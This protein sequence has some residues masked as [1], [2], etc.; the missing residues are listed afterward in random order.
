M[1]IILCTYMPGRHA[2]NFM[3]TR[4]EC[5]VQHVCACGVCVFRHVCV[6]VQTLVCMCVYVYVRAFVRSLC[7][8]ACTS[9][10][11]ACARTHHIHHHRRAEA[12]SLALQRHTAR[13]RILHR[14]DTPLLFSLHSAA[15]PARASAA[16]TAHLRGRLRLSRALCPPA[17]RPARAA[18]PCEPVLRTLVSSYHHR[19]HG[20]PVLHQRERQRCQD[21][22]AP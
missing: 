10:R 21:A 20:T 17:P 9:M 3:W 15:R 8:H 12:R 22:V 16:A 7:N 14:Q 2:P 6:Y 18:E 4:P 1:C 19:L 5:H 11:H 13:T